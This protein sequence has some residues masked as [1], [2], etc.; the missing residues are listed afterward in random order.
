[1]GQQMSCME[2]PFPEVPKYSGHA[3]AGWYESI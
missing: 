3:F 1:M 2:Q